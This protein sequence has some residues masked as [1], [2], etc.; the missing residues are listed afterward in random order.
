MDWVTTVVVGTFTGLGAL[1]IVS[2]VQTSRLIR[3][4]RE[5]HE[6]IYESLGRPTLLLN[7]SVANSARLMAFLWKGRFRETSDQ[8]LIQCASWLRVIQA[9]YFALFA[10]AL[11][12]FF[13]AVAGGS[14]A[15]ETSESGTRTARQVA[16]PSDLP[17][18]HAKF[19]FDTRGHN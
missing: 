4:L 9:A 10:T 16:G 6:R 14:G 19:R 18:R 11:F 1:L 7:N 2:A 13:L 17:L 12:L 3:M 15:A 8:E 5:R